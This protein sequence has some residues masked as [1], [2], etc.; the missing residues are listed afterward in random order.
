MKKV[1]LSI[2]IAILLVG[3]SSSPKKEPIELSAQ[4]VVNRLNDENQDSFLLFITNDQCYACEEYEKVIASIEEIQP[5]EIYYMYLNLE[6]SDEAVIQT[7]K[8]LT[9]TTGP[10]EQLP[11]T[12]YF[13]QGGLQEDNKKAGYI[14]KRDMIEWLRNL[15]I[16]H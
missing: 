13:Y 7:L 8:E 3:C 2:M 1:I 11:M 12:Y 10:I 9:V 15:H 6:E 16:L 14:E 5:F 4:Q